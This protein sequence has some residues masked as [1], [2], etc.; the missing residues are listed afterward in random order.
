MADPAMAA[1]SEE[2]DTYSLDDIV[3]TASRIPEKV[4]DAKADVSIVNREKIEKL[5]YETLEDA[6]RSVPGTQFT[7][8]GGNGLNGN[9]S[10]I[11]INGSNDIVILVDGVRI[12]SF[13]GAGESGHI[14]GA[15][16]NNMD[17]IERVEVLRGSA[18]TMYGSGAKGGV[19]NI[20]TRN[21]KENKT[22]VDV[23]T[24]SGGSNNIRLHTMG[25]VDENKLAYSVYYDRSHTGDTIAGDGKRWPGYSN[26]ESDGIKLV[27]DFTKDHSLMMSFDHTKSDFSGEDYVYNDHYTG[28]YLSD[29]FTVQDK[30]NFRD[31][32][33]NILTFRKTHIDSMYIEN[34]YNPL[35]A[36]DIIPDERH[37]TFVSDQLSFSDKNNDAVIGFDY[38]YTHDDVK[39]KIGEDEYGDIILG[40]HYISNQSFFA[41]ETWRFAKGFSLTGGVRHD[42]PKP[43]PYAPKYA[44]HTSKSWKLSYEPTKLDTIYFGKSDY[45]ILPPIGK[46]Y[47]P[48]YGNDQLK[49]A[50]G[51]TT[52][53]GYTHKFGESTAVTF[54]WFK[55]VDKVNIGYDSDLGRYTNYEN[56]E[57]R[58]WNLQFVS[59]P[60]K[61]WDINVGWAHLKQSNIKET[62]VDNGYA[63]K[64]KLT[65]AIM[66]NHGKL[67]TGFDGFY[68]IRNTTST[69][70]NAFPSDKYGIYNLSFTYSPEKNYSFYLRI[71]NL[72]NT[73]WAEH[74]DVPYNHNP[75][76]WYSMPGR[77]F[78]LGVKVSF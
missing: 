65:F 37:G 46:L 16:T 67:T 69:S 36:P 48:I 55:T 45:Y 66:Y 13:Q 50:E 22:T 54:N 62:F 15:L 42:R 77:T 78:T 14:Y 28:N 68:F 2:L 32:W 18:A 73:L 64:D 33:S 23:S 26:T 25:R 4:I 3:V 40:H 12:N 51:Q 47:D 53:I 56:G 63:P 72:F 31:H 6:L 21:P 9:I 41:Q 52:S 39:R 34:Y 49:P 29:V 30:I 11:R 1:E 75:E 38:T 70:K 7:N 44:D 5:H 43:D 58:G 8:Y 24:G 17:N 59:R 35:L 60:S 10:S 27:Y 74:T 20:I 71:N 61:F 19:I 76:S 57:S